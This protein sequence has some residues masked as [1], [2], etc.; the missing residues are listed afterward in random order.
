MPHSLS[1][2]NFATCYSK[3]LASEPNHGCQTFTCAP[4]SASLSTFKLLTAGR[5]VSCADEFSVAFGRG[6]RVLVSVEIGLEHAETAM[7]NTSNISQVFRKELMLIGHHGD[8]SE[9]QEK[10]EQ[11]EETKRTTLRVEFGDVIQWLCAHV[12]KPEQDEHPQ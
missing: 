7:M 4:R 8:G 6:V 2:L 9:D 12:A 1:L 10:N 3:R 5:G 11:D